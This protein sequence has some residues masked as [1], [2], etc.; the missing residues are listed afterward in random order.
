[1]L[2]MIDCYPQLWIENVDNFF[3]IAECKQA[4]EPSPHLSVKRKLF[5]RESRLSGKG[6]ELPSGGRC[7]IIHLRI[8]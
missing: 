3:L 1:M 5:L 2:G 7:V 4:V 6:G 8:G